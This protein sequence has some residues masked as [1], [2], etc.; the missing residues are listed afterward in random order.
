MVGAYLGGSIFSPG[1][2]LAPTKIFHQFF[3]NS[4]LGITLQKSLDKT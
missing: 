1:P 2:N 3:K 4:Y